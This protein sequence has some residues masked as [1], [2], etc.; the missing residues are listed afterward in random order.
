[1]FLTHK[2]RADYETAVKLRAERKITTPGEPFQQSD[3]AEMNTLIA[4]GV[5]K[6]AEYDSSIHAGRIFKS[7]MVR[8]VKARETDHPSEIRI[9]R[10]VD[11]SRRH[12]D[13]H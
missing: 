2:E 4:K 11:T 8:T 13:P 7:R 12:D 1:M 6:V 10:R 9:Q 3:Q 5:I